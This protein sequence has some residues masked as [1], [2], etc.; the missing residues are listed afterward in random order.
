MIMKSA[1]HAA[2]LS[3]LCACSSTPVATAAAASASNGNPGIVTFPLLSHQ[4]V[5]QRHL[6][7]L[8]STPHGRRLLAA[9]NLTS[10]SFD[11]LP[12]HRPRSLSSPSQQLS[13][14]YQGYGTH[15]LD[16]W[17]GL[18]T[19]QRQTAVVDTGSSATAFPCL[20]CR[21]CGTHADPPF[22]ETAS[23][24]FR[25]SVCPSKPCAFGSC[26]VKGT[27]LVAH[28]YGSGDDASSWIA[29]EAQDV[30]Y[31]GGSHDGPI[32]PTTPPPSTPTTPAENSPPPLPSSPSPSP[33]AARLP[34]PG[35][36][37]AT[38]LRS[39]RPRPQGPILLGPNVHLPDHPPCPI[40][41]LLRPPARRVLLGHPRRRGEF[42]RCQSQIA[43][44]AHGVRQGNGAREHDQI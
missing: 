1:A 44:L 3:S 6:A 24:S 16:L 22:N 42:R 37:E 40:L 4:H 20:E 32:P 31:A 39:C 17:L 43:R 28:E 19:P 11:R 2:I 34:P 27:C 21:D 7:E 13:P 18:P 41:P 38:R 35:T 25:V 15:Y 14:L 9:H 23:L 33:S 36:S 10:S 30:V 29:F 26:D 8:S 5:V 12:F